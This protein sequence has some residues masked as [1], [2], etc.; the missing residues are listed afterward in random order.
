MWTGARAAMAAAA[1]AA[2]LAAGALVGFG[3]PRLA[4]RIHGAQGTLPAASITSVAPPV[5]AAPAWSR[6]GAT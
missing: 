6:P 5:A 1:V 4:A 2:G 3:V